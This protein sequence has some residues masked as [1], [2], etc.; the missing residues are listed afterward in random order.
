MSKIIIYES[1]LNLIAQHAAH[2]PDLE[3]GGDLFG[4]WTHTGNPVIQYV[5]GAGPD[6]QRYETAFYQDRAFLETYGAA[7]N[8]QHA[9]QH[10]GEWH[11]HHHLAM[12]HPSGGDI[13][14]VRNALHTYNLK[15]FVLCI[16]NLEELVR[17]DGYLFSA[18]ASAAHPYHDCSWVVLPGVSPLRRVIDKSLNLR[19]PR[20]TDAILWHVEPQTTLEASSGTKATLPAEAW[21]TTSTGKACF[22]A[23]YKVIRQTCEDVRLFQQADQDIV[24]LCREGDQYLELTFP[25]DFPSAPY[26]VAFAMEIDTHGRLVQPAPLMPE[27]TAEQ[28]LFEALDA[29]VQQY[30]PAADPQ[31]S[32]P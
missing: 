1:E 23:L 20:R 27:E 32:Q 6:A 25:P 29:I 18:Q 8:A 3:T 10:L 2:Y 7:I 9:L 19:G 17:V 24:L 15:R 31:E 21:L 16:C 5:L 11:S 22:Q 12:R 28:A 13:Q 4:L 26:R 30:Y 14:T